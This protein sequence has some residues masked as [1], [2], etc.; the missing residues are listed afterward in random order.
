[1]RIKRA[2]CNILSKNFPYTLREH[3]LLEFHHCFLKSCCKLLVEKEKGLLEGSIGGR[4]VRVRIFS[5]GI[6][7][8]RH[9]GGETEFT[10][11]LPPR[12][13]IVARFCLRQRG[14]PVTGSS[15]CRP[16]ASC[17]NL[18][19]MSKIESRGVESRR[20]RRRRRSNP[21][22]F[23]YNTLSRGLKSVNPRGKRRAETCCCSVELDPVS[24]VSIRYRTMTRNIVLHFIAIF[25][26]R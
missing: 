14:Y 4:R 24:L 25:P 1:M 12:D 6:R 18:A 2:S 17:R 9:H 20:R 16:L 10:R 19:L 23:F 7:V 15:C 13:G 11:V 22:L 8:P 21:S 5:R 26:I 3:K